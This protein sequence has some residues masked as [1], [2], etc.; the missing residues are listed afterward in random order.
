[1]TKEDAMKFPF[2]A[3]GMLCILYGAIT[4]FGKEIVNP[5]LLTYISLGGS[6]AISSGLLS[7]GIGEK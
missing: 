1:M 4:Y 7:F 3:G 6:T 5:M 2:L